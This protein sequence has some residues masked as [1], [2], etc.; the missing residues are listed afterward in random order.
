V[1]PATPTIRSLRLG[2]DY[3][4]VPAPTGGFGAQVLT[5]GPRLLAG[6]NRLDINDIILKAGSHRVKDGADLDKLVDEA[7][8]DRERWLTVY[9]TISG[10]SRVFDF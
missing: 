1:P 2:I 10:T 7:I 4:I 3:V 8:G 5:R 9:N 6:T